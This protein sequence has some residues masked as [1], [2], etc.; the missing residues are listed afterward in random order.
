MNTYLSDARRS[1][2]MTRKRLENWSET[3]K[4]CQATCDRVPDRQHTDIDPVTALS[5]LLLQIR[6]RY[7]V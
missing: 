6:K 3:E 7:L 1:M 4:C 2:D 5:G